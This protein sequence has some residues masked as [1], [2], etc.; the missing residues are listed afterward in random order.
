MINQTLNNNSVLLF[1]FG[2]ILVGLS[3]E[4]CVRALEQIGCGRIAYYVD[5]CRQEDLFHEL[6]IG[7]SIEAFCDEARRQSSYTDEKGVY[8]PCKA[9]NDEICWAWN[10]LLLDI[11]VEKLRLIHHLHH[12]LGIHTAILSNTN[13]I[14]WQYA[15]RHLF[16][17]D[18]LTVNDYFD[19]IFLSCD[20]QMVKPDDCIY[21]E[22]VRQLREGYGIPALQP[23]DILF[24]DDS[25]KNC[26][27]AEANGIRA[28]HDPNGDKWMTKLFAGNQQ[29]PLPEKGLCGGCIGNFD[30]IHL[31]H[32][33]VI[34]MLKRV[35]AERGLRP[36]VITFDRHPR[37]LFDPKFEPEYLTTVQ[38]K[39]MLL[40]DAGVD[41]KVMP[42]TQQL[43]D[44]TARDYMRRLYD[45]MDVRLL[46]LG[47]DNRFGKRNEYETFED[48]QR[49]G[50]ELGI[51]VLR[52][53][54]IDVAGSR[55]SSSY[56]RH[57]V[58]EGR[59]DDASQCLGY[60]FS[61]AGTV[62]EGHRE[63]RK[64]GFP[65][66]NINAPYGKIVPAN[67]VYET[68]T[69]I[70]GQRYKSVT[71]IG[72][73]PTYDNGD[74]RSIETHVIGFDGTLYGRVITVGFVRRLRDEI[75]FASPDD[76]R[77]QIDLDVSQVAP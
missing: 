57:L 58:R 40:R 32:R 28:F 22:M 56:V 5:E 48:Y 75:P 66:A 67:G 3:K 16:T 30:G 77:K 2:T 53:D 72:T 44:T 14:H 38:E 39:E 1:D 59:V 50:S 52:A 18:G 33:H 60:L 7:G 76:L 49:Y 12:D 17:A 11:P 46:L 15:V 13:Q 27:A 6:E 54:A 20:M 74:Q 29:Q 45:D 71:N 61:I 70:D 51:E 65:T 73:R 36:V 8:H 31:G 23:H 10:Q 37:A 42:F 47:Y 25:A 69:T 4:R 34:D 19:E 41:V 24:I 26:M 35:A 63:G 43:A 62:V 55:V 64:I 21:Q 68:E 9:T